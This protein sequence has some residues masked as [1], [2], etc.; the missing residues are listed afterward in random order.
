MMPVPP[1]GPALPVPPV[2]PAGPTLPVPP[3]T[4]VL[5]REPKTT[6]H[7]AYASQTLQSLLFILSSPL[8]LTHLS[9]AQNIHKLSKLLCKFFFWKIYTYP[10]PHDANNIE[11]YTFITVFLGNLAPVPLHYVTLE[12]PLE[13]I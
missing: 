9:G 7:V 8:F 13:T 4:P 2:C 3:V 10:P 6:T 1:L 5:P 11:Q 12:W